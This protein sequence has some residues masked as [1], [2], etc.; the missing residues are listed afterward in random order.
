MLRG[1]LREAHDA[2]EHAH[3]EAAAELEAARAAW[4]VQSREEWQ[5]LADISHWQAKA[6]LYQK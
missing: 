3:Q 2:L 1:Q 6:L 4:Q 5:V